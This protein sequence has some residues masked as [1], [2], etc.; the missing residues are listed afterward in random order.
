MSE[1][2]T[3]TSFGIANRVAVVSGGNRNIGRS[4]V[5]TLAKEGAKPVI[6]YRDGADEANKVCAEVAA[7]GAT[8]VVESFALDRLD[9]VEAWV[10]VDGTRIEATVTVV[11]PATLL[12]LDRE[13]LFE[14][15]ADHTDLLQGLFSNLVRGDE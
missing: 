7:L 8:P 1:Q 10:A 11:E 6:L 9:P 2:H 4:I 14:L 3:G 13:E 5:L 12:K 15:L